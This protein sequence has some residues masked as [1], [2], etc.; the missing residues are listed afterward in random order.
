MEAAGE[1]P[2]R[3]WIG[4]IKNMKVQI[5][6]AWD[7]LMSQPEIS[8]DG[9]DY[10]SL[11]VEISNLQSNDNSAPTLKWNIYGYSKKLKNNFHSGQRDTFDDALAAWQEE[12]AV[13]LKKQSA[14]RFIK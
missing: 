9:N 4:Q 14:G 13:R 7:E 12:H 11:S 10:T 1:F 8:D 5:K 2:R 3:V 6:D